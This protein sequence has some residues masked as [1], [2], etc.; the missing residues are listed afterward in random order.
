MTL[1]VVFIALLFFYSLI[2][3]LL[4]RSIITAPIL[5]TVGGILLVPISPEL[6]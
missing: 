2:S 5:F 1:I 4:T 6:A 3:K